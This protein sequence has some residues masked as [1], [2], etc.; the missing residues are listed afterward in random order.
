[1]GPEADG[2]MGETT[3]LPLGADQRVLK[4]LSNPFRYKVFSRLNERPW[5]ATQLAP[6]LGERWERV[7]EEI[8][9][10][11]REGLAE[12]VGTEA[13]PDGGRVHLYRAERFY[14]TA[15]QWAE[16]PEEARSAGSF[17][18]LQLIFGEAM[19]ALESGA[20]ESRADRVLARNPIHTDDIGARQIET[21]MVR[22]LEEVDAVVAE[23]LQRSRQGSD[24]PAV[25]LLTAFLSIPV[26]ASG[27]ENSPP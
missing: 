16:F 13:G 21:I 23:S 10:L 9:V 1:M 22:A 2:K 26:G 20:L 18:V 25:R 6:L 24:Q 8:R 14:F 19:A 17:T 5:S 27:G 4:L 12:F 3:H 11:R 7:R 15:E